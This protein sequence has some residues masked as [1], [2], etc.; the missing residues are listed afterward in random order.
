MVDEDRVDEDFRL[1]S[2]LQAASTLQEK[3]YKHCS[4]QRDDQTFDSK[5]LE[6]SG[7][8]KLIKS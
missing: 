3:E 5:E 1:M 7:D 4:L 8:S 2:I 6:E